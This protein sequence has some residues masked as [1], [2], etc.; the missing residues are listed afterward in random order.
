MKSYL[1]VI[2]I[3][4]VCATPAA[5]LAAQT[6]KPPAEPG[7]GSTAAT[8]VPEKDGKAIE[9]STGSAFGR[10]FRDVGRDYKNTFSKETAIWYGAGLGAAG[11][12]HLADESIRGYLEDPPE[13]AAQALEGGDVYGNATF[14]LPLAVGWWAVGHAFGSSRGAE[15][16]RDLLRAQINAA[17]W[18]YAIKFAVDRTRPNGEPRS[19]PSGHASATFASAMVLQEHYGWKVGVPFFAAATYTAVSRISVDKHWASDVVFGAAIGMASGRTVT[20]RL[21]KRK[22]AL[23]P[24]AVPGG[25]G[26]VLVESN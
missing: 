2:G 25:G 26:I 24:I 16:G 3:F 14:Q 23:M 15:A 22:I 10:F 6:E 7:A 4:L 1:L 9:P 21:R 12:V 19:F 11:L 5:R 20:L 13:P 8:T 18:T 17:T